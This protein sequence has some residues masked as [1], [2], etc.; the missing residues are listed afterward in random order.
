MTTTEKAEHTGPA[1]QDKADAA[2]EAA[3]EE[4]KVARRIRKVKQPG[5][6]FE[7]ASTK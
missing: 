3:A 6:Q 2:A 5:E 4:R 1:G 7:D